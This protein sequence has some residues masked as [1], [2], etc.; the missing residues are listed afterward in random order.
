M[1]KWEPLPL[2]GPRPHS[3]TAMGEV[4]QPG[5]DRQVSKGVFHFNFGERLH[6]S[7]IWKGSM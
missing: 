4:Q 3:F 1:T 6:F 7:R 2:Y 5:Q